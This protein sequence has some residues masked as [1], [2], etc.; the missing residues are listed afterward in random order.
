MIIFGIGAAI[1]ALGGLGVAY[2]L[3]AGAVGKNAKNRNQVVPGVKTNAPASWAGAHEPEAKLHRRLR[4]AVAALHTI[5]G[6]D[7]TMQS[8]IDRVE[9]DAVDLDNQLVATSQL[10]STHRERAL[11]NVS[12]A[13]E[14]LEEIAAQVV[15]RS[16]TNSD[17]SIQDQLDDLAVRME[18]MRLARD[19]VDEVDRR[20]QAE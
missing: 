16:A 3:G 11:S 18:S 19:E 13:V 15:D 1:L 10:A 8:L 4:D 17:R 6:K 20:W 9:R 14:N 2:V 5:A 12:N 7:D